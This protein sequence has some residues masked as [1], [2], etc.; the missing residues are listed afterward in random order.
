MG[1][2]VLEINSEH[3]AV[4]LDKSNRIHIH[5]FVYLVRGNVIILISCICCCEV[6]YSRNKVVAMAR[7]ATIIVAMVAAVFFL[8][9]D[10]S[11]KVVYT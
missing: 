7:T 5:F 4:V 11:V 8:L 6:W 9:M 10:T 2:T 3:L 1:K